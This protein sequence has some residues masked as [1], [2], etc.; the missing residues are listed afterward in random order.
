MLNLYLG[1]GKEENIVERYNDVV[2]FIVMS[3]VFVKGIVYFDLVNFEENVE[4]FF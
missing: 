4:I 1:I 3:R 2:E